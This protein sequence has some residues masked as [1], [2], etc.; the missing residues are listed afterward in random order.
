MAQA[1]RKKRFFDV[2]IPLINKE[3]QLQAYEISELDGRFMKYDLTRLIRGK[4]R[5]RKKPL[6]YLKR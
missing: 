3:T 5:I 6:P 1:K 4:A 2:E